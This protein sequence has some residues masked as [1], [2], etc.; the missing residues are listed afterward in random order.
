MFNVDQNERANIFAQEMQAQGYTLDQNEMERIEVGV[1]E[2]IGQSLP[3]LIKTLA[4][5][6][7]LLPV[8]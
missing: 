1:G 8:P 3:G 6:L 5:E 4:A 2:M 7:F